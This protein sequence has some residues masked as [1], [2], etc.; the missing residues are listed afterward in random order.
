MDIIQYPLPSFTKDRTRRVKYIVIHYVSA[1]NVPEYKQDP[2]NIEGVLNLF[3]HEG[4]KYK[5]SCH[6]LIARNG[7]IYQMINSNDTAWHAGRSVIACPNY[8]RDINSSS[9]GIELVGMDND[10][11]THEQYQSLA[12]LSLHIEKEVVTNSLGKIIRYVGHSDIS[13]EIAVKLGVKDITVM[14]IDPGKYF[15]WL[16]FYNEKARIAL[17]TE[18]KTNCL[19]ELHINVLAQLSIAECIQLVLK[20]LFKKKK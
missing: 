3:K 2:Y 20:K 5:F 17:T 6:Y 19:P 12:Q 18:I 16:T 10:S 9:V 8:E 13:G 7:Q 14:K 1:K 15:D 11:F 4:P